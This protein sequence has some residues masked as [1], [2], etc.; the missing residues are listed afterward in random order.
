MKALLSDPESIFFLGGAMLIILYLGACA[1]LGVG[2]VLIA[3]R[4]TRAF[5]HDLQERLTRRASGS[6]VAPLAWGSW[7]C[8]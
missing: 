2:L 6:A 5:A 4:G 8:H 3:F 1:G 7:P